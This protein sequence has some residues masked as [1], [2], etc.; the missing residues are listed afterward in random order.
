MFGALRTYIGRRDMRGLKLS[1]I[2]LMLALAA[3]ADQGGDTTEDAAANGGQPA[4][5]P[6]DAGNQAQGTASG[7]P[8]QGATAEDVTAGQQIFTATG[9]CFTC[10]GPDAKGTALAPNLTDSEWINIDGTFAAIQQVVKTGVATPKEHP[11]PMPAMGGVQ[12]SDD[13]IRQVAAY[14]W[15]LGGGK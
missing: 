13:Q 1:A 15:S 5:A 7:T 2:A 6:Q 9:N 12:L 11:A 3:C 4:G 14:V 8:P 10:H